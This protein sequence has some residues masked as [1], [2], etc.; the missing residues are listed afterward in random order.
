MSPRELAVLVRSLPSMPRT[1][2][3]DAIEIRVLGA[4]LE[5]EQTT[6]DNYPLTVNTLIAACNQKT[7]RD[8]VTSLTETEVV[9]ALDRLRLDALT[10]RID[11]GRA[12]RWEHRL[13]RRWN[14][15]PGRKALMTLLLLRGAQTPGELK[16][17]AERM[18]RFESLEDVEA[19]LRRLAGKEDDLD[20]LVRE[21]ER[22][23]GERQNRW[24]HL[25]G[26]PEVTAELSAAGGTASPAETGPGPEPVREVSHGPSA[27]DRLDALEGAVDELRE[28]VEALRE[29]LAGLRRRLGDA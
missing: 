11:S 12:E 24:I 23:P 9:E 5:K 28:G 2:P 8:P 17:R 21:L 22:H 14:L 26:T 4:L 7:A 20:T 29:E 18:H 10:W 15:E 16:S 13:D 3:L 19:A 27:I 6:P 25:A 1:R